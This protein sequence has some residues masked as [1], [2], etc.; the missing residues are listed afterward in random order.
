M[1]GYLNN[2]EATRATI[3]PDGW[4]HTGDIAVR[5]E[6]G[7]YFIV[8]RLKELIKYKGFQV[9]PAELEAILINHPDVADCAV[10]GVPDEDAGEIPK[11]FVV[12]AE[13]SDLDHDA[14]MAHVAEQVSPQKKM[15]LVEEID[16]IPKSA[17]GKILRR[18]LMDRELPT[19]TRFRRYL[20]PRALVSRSSAA[21]ADAARRVGDADEDDGRQVERDA[22]LGG[23]QVVPAAADLDR[24]P[25]AVQAPSRPASRTGPA[26]SRI[27]SRPSCLLPCL[28]CPFAGWTISVST[29]P[30]ERGCRKATWLLRMPVRGSESISSMPASASCASVALMSSTR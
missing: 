20:V 23:L 8:D 12:P 18:V 1:A 10:I 6:D 19:G 16:E 14:L 13:G 26:R 27:R 29:P 11:A 5:D 7:F 17:S 22:S 24:L 21:E 9:P 15:R 28:Q 30:V 25:K 3:D 4:L 2:E